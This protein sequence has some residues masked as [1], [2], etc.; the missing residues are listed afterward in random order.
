MRNIISQIREN[1]EIIKNSKS[2]NQRDQ[3]RA[4]NK[5]LKKELKKFKKR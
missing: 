4:R 1:N 3:A 5:K 2:P